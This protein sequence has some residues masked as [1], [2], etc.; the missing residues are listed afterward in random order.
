MPAL[1]EAGILDAGLTH[2]ATRTYH[3]K[4]N[5]KVFCDNVSRWP[6]TTAGAPSAR[7]SD[8]VVQHSAAPKLSYAIVCS[9]WMA[10]EQRM[11]G[12]WSQC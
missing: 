1:K 5:W 12:T 10:G 4:C 3:L 2:V 8:D 11:Y 7:C 6:Q 9:T